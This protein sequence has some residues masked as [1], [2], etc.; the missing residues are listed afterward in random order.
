MKPVT[1]LFAI[2]SEMEKE[3]AF[4]R[5][6]KPSDSFYYDDARSEFLEKDFTSDILFRIGM[7]SD[8]RMAEYLARRITGD[9]SIEIDEVETEPVVENIGH[10]VRLDA[11]ARDRKGTLYDFEMQGYREEGM[12]KRMR[13][14]ESSLTLSSLC[15]GKSYSE[16]PDLVMIVFHTGD[17]YGRGR[18]LYVSRFM[19]EEGFVTDSSLVRYEVNLSFEGECTISDIIHDM[20]TSDGNG[21][22]TEVLGDI[23]KAIKENREMERRYKSDSQMWME[24]GI[25]KGREQGIA[26]GLERGIAEGREQGIAQG[27][28]RGIAQG[29]EKGIAQGMEKGIAQGVEKGVEKS[30]EILLRNGLLSPEEIER[31][32]HVPLEEIM[33]IKNRLS[34]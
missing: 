14:Y 31:N 7:E 29:M 8:V 11:L 25:A 13:M 21:M 1:I 2:V 3:V 6:D 28:E 9:E 18:P 17:P 27:M 33:S 4:L 22:E 32:F 5:E 12:G 19:D 24:R 26:Q 10:S 15:K 30:I 20:K 16:V 23:M 34:E